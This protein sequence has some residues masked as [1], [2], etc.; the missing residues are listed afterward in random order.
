[1]KCPDCG[2]F[3]SLAVLPQCENCG[4]RFPHLADWEGQ[5]PAQQASEPL[6]PWPDELTQRVQ[7]FRQ[8]RARLRGNFDPES[9]LE[10]DFE[11]SSADDRLPTTARLVGPPPDREL[12]AVLR[13]EEDTRGAVPAV[14]SVALRRESGLLESS[15]L[16]ETVEP[17]AEGRRRRPEPGA[18]PLMTESP[19]S[20]EP[21][22]GG[23]LVPPAPLS[24]RF[25][26]GVVDGIVLLLALALFAGTFWWIVGGRLHLYP[27]RLAALGF[28]AGFLVFSYFALFGR[29]AP[30]TP[31]QRALDLTLRSLEGS[32]PTSG[33][34]IWRAIGYLVSCAALMLGFAWALFDIDGLTWHDRMSGTFLASRN[35][36]L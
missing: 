16:E 12:D 21:E 31:G 17:S 29:L 27:G 26:A 15:R 7:K 20:D 19:P 11:G 8:R 5:P 36:E 34:A 23:E 10:F 24:Q 6:E 3:V 33:Q 2:G 14:D 9:T 18:I 13:A 25:L 1:M 35:P 32:A 4:R 30:A 28:V 22:S